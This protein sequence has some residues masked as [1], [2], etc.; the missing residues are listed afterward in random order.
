LRCALIKAFAKK[1]AIDFA[2]KKNKAPEDVKEQYEQDYEKFK[3][4]E[5]KRN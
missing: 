1:H 5:I 2:M 3:K 4:N